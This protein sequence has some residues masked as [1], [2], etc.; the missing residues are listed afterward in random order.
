M[1]TWE[2]ELILTDL[3]ED[4][5]EG[6]SNP[7]KFGEAVA[8]RLEQLPNFNLQQIDREKAAILEELRSLKP[9][10]DWDVTD[11]VIVRLY[12]WGDIFI[13]RGP[14]PGCNRRV[15]WIKAD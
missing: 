8:E 5:R 15:C 12:D 2:R 14:L 13:E 6:R 10:D 11:D 7:Q 9:L 1:A 3:F 4:A